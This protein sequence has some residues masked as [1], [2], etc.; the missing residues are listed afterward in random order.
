M[1]KVLIALLILV[2]LMSL[3]GCNASRA[4]TNT[5]INDYYFTSKEYELIK[6]K[7]VFS[8]GELEITCQDDREDGD[9]V[10]ADYVGKEKE[11][12]YLYTVISRNQIECEG[13][14]YTFKLNT[15]SGDGNSYAWIV[16]DKDFLGINEHWWRIIA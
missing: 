10:G 14:I 1:K 6:F 13:I 2:M 8:E 9:V 5:L 7:L 3:L 15:M 11:G 16:F 12:V 4:I